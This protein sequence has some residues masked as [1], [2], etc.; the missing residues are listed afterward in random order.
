MGCYFTRRE[1]D[2]ER[3]C[4]S[5]SE[6]NHRAY[7]CLVTLSLTLPDLRESRV[8]KLNFQDEVVRCGHK[9]Q[10]HAAAE[11]LDRICTLDPFRFLS[12]TVQ[13]HPHACVLR[14]N[15]WKL[16]GMWGASDVSRPVRYRRK[17]GGFLTSRPLH[18]L[19]KIERESTIAVAS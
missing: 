1:P 10:M 12:L 3:I 18:T 7:E 19:Q 16:F 5:T 6:L 14:S 2:A 9:W 8:M 11:A 4:T 13:V 17:I 15:G